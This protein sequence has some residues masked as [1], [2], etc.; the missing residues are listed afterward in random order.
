MVVGCVGN[1]RVYT[2]W[3]AALVANGRRTVAD[4]DREDNG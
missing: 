3:K 1:R 4:D 2:I